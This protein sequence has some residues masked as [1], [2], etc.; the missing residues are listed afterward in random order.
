MTAAYNKIYLDDAI[1]CL[2][3]ALEYVSNAC[4][5]N[6]NIFMD[7]FIA[8]G[9]ATRF[10]DGEPAI[11]S[12]T[13]GSELVRKV[14]EGC[15]LN[16]SFPPALID[17]ENASFEFCCGQLLAYIQWYSGKRFSDILK[18]ISLDDLEDYVQKFVETNM[19]GKEQIAKE[20]L[21]G[22]NESVRIQTLRKRCGYSQRQLAEAAHV[23]IRTLQ[24]YE[25]KSMDINKAAASTVL[26][27]SRTMGCTIEDLMEFERDEE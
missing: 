24:Q 20:I 27:L 11:V 17:Y 7:M 9:I 12:G 19:D 6:T 21:S 13:S 23:N 8:S 3:E 16:I 26:E 15:G 5:I 2:G 10:E 14:V 25:I 1:D 22:F 18:N 4:Q